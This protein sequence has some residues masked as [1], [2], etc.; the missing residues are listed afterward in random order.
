MIRQLDSVYLQI[1]ADPSVAMELSDHFSFVSPAA[2]FSQ[3]YRNGRWDGKTR[4]FSTT[5]HKIYAG[6]L[7]KIVDW[8]DD[9]GYLVTLDPIETAER[10]L[11]DS[12]RV[13]RLVYDSLKLPFVPYDHQI[14]ALTASIQNK[15]ALILSSTSSGKSLVIYA[16]CRMYQKMGIKT[17][18]IVPSINLV[19]QMKG[20]FED[21]AKNDAWSVD[22]NVQT[23]S[24]GADRTVVKPI[25]VSTWQAIVDEPTKW[26]RQFSSVVGDECHGFKAKSLQTI[27]KKLDR[28]P[29][30]VGFTGTLDGMEIHELIVEG[31]FGPVFVAARAKDLIDKKI[32]AELMIHC[33]VLDH[34]RLD[35]PPLEYQDEIDYLC[36]S[37]DRNKFLEE[38]TSRC[39][40]N[41]LLLFQ[42]VEKHG[43]VLYEQFK[44]QFGSDRVFYVSG[45]VSGEERDRIRH[46]VESRNDAIILGSYGTFS[47]GVNIKRLHNVV[48]ASPSK[49]KVR[50]IQSIGRGLR[51][52]QTKKSVKVWDI[53]DIIRREDKK[54]CYSV[55]HLKERVNHYI[56]EDY[57]YM[58]KPM[59]LPKCKER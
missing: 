2:K 35:N 53:S 39:K 5:T 57:P 34:G 29:Y 4:L 14:N 43:K 15:R 9:S 36:R 40:G 27:M 56:A 18:V 45:E 58:M 3:A 50:V 49:A 28:C 51:I 10:S 59:K 37:S 8:A 46:E 55:R 24:E 33:L 44:K 30:R 41:T 22:E 42:Y 23:I 52:T 16:L 38:L 6:L 54:E 19:R 26:F 13:S 47:T 11:E 17:L 32:S 21:Y 12:E 31:V 48:F 1:D 25:V 20:D 7:D